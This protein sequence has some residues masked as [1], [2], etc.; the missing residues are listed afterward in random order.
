MKVGVFVAVGIAAL[1]TGCDNAAEKMVERFPT[2]PLTLVIPP[3]YEIAVHGK[4]AKVFGRNECPK[5]DTSMQFLFG[6]SSLDGSSD[7]V[8]ITPTTKDVL[9]RVVI[10]GKLTD[11]KWI[12]ERS[13][14]KPARVSLRRPGGLPVMGYDAFLKA[15]PNIKDMRGQI[16]ALNAKGCVAGGPDGKPL[17]LP[18]HAASGQVLIPRGSTFT[19]EC[20]HEGKEP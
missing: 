16:L 14:Q 7:C 5:E 11:E 2:K 3:G 4:A 17:Q 9:A 1:L 20:F 6:P 15:N 19:P 12:V 10:D 13:D 18:E 8:V